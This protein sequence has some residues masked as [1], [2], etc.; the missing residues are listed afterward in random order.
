MSARIDA[1]RPHPLYWLVRREL[2]EN[3]FVWAVPALVA[4]IVFVTNLVAAMLTLSDA[5]RADLLEVPARIIANLEMSPAPI[6]FSSL[7]VGLFFAI[8]ALH[9][10]RRDRSILFWKS[11]PVSDAKTV[12]SKLLIPIA[13]APAIGLALCVV[14]QFSLL[15]AVT[16]LTR[17]T[18]IP[19]SAVWS[20]V[21]FFE[22]LPI[23][24]YGLSAHVLWYAPIYAW[25]L[26]IS[27][28]ARRAPA[29]W[30]FVPPLIVV[31]LEL[32]VLGPSVIGYAILYRLRGVM[33]IAFDDSPASRKGHI[34]SLLQLEPLALLTSP[35]LW[36]GLL[37]TAA[38]TLA[39]IYLRRRREPH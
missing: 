17:A 23:M 20:D 38:A 35:A 39:A 7:L 33:E 6:M 36:L 2:W 12:L 31:A 24:V 10:E 15:I 34:D 5:S 25:A 37:F 16:L 30:F 19:A 14:T 18:A 4:L 8:D 9:G 29:L 21:A 32:M 28:W 22:G 3:R 11:L 27:V 26:L 1:A 13:I